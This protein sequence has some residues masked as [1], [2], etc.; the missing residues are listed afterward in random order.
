MKRD[1]NGTFMKKNT[2]EFLIPSL[3]FLIKYFS[4]LFIL[5]PWIYFAIYKINI[6]KIYENA[7]LYLFGA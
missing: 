1:T 7:L 4:I 3:S 2:I 5:L 6:G